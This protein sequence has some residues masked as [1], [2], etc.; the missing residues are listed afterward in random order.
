M[1]TIATA[2][3]STTRARRHTM[4]LLVIVGIN[5]DTV[6]HWN[7]A[8]C[9]VSIETVLRFEP[10]ASPTLSTPA[11]SGSCLGGTP[12]QGFLWSSATV[13][14]AVTSSHYPQTRSDRG[15]ALRV[16]SGGSPP[17]FVSSRRAASSRRRRPRARRRTAPRPTR[18]AA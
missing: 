2:S 1:A 17:P 5:D 11:P 15:A 7:Q 13:S 10:N 12:C 14:G 9:Q 16:T 4:D 6:L 8:S 18:A 3:V